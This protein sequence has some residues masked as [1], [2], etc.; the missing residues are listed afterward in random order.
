[1]SG[2][3]ARRRHRHR[4]RHHHRHQH[5]HRRRSHRYRLNRCPQLH[6]L[7]RVRV[8]LGQ[9]R[10]DLGMAGRDGGFWVGQEGSVWSG[11]GIGWA[12]PGEIIGWIWVGWGGIGGLVRAS[13]CCWRSGRTT[14]GG[15]MLE[16]PQKIVVRGL[17]CGSGHVALAFMVR[18]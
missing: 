11:V 5:H 6:R 14:V 17:S 3:T 12:W 2:F 9:G 10:V 16:G 18:S 4:Y 13:Q 15:K 8:G 7:G 1:M